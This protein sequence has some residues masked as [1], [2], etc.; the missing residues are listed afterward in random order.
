MRGFAVLGILVM[1]VVAIGMPIYAY[2]DPRYYGGASGADLV[3]W[4]LAYVLADGKMRALFTM[5]FGASLV[6][7]AERAER[8]AALHYRRMA[9]LFLIGMAHCWLLWFGDI[10]VEYAVTGAIAFMGWRWRA[11]SL[12]FVTGLC[13]ALT[14]A[15]DLLAWSQLSA[16]R[17]AAAMPGAAPAIL[18]RWAEVVAT[19]RPDPA[20]IA[21]EIAL[22]RGG[23]AD[24]F[25]ARAPAAL[26]FQTRVL[27][28]TVPETLGY[29]TLG[30]ALHRHGFFTG[31]WPR[32]AYRWAVAGGVMVL[33]LYVMLAGWLV[34]SG[35]DP[36]ARP[37]ADALGFLLRP[38]LALAY[39]AAIIL[40]VRSGRVAGLV[41][42][43][44]AAG[45]MALSNY[46]GSTLIATTLFY[47]YGAGLYGQLGRAQLYLIVVPVWVMILSWSSAWLDRFGYG[48][49]EWLWRALSGRR[50]SSA[51]N[52]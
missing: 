43:L 44:A 51:G 50:T 13:F 11:T 10:L 7:I 8:P 34:G 46:L 3:A 52:N 49:A 21:R 25:A 45:R 42:R 24:A 26:M 9:G 27:P 47:G 12:L 33:P 16:L 28:L 17:D 5:L 32:A 40:L 18:A 23:F 4:A 31:A 36:V 20:A 19:A 2:S 30:M 1:N 48:P 15:D 35:F 39:A 37:L 22:Y 14:I 29:V 6:L 41:R 38:W